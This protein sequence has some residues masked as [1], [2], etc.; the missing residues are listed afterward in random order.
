MPNRTSL[1]LAPRRAGDWIEISSGGDSRALLLSGQPFG[2][3]VVGQGPF[4]MNTRE[5]IQ[6]A[7]LDYQSGKMGHLA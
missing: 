6:Q 5:E 2:E 3:P 1:R 7:I 4:V